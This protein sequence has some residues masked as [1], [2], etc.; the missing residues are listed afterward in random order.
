M[1]H[2]SHPNLFKVLK[3]LA[4]VII[5]SSSLQGCSKV[6]VYPWHDSTMGIASSNRSSFEKMRAIKLKGE[7]NRITG[8]RKDIGTYGVAT[9][10]EQ[11]NQQSLRYVL[12]APVSK[13]SVADIGSFDL[14]RAIQLPVADAIALKDILKRFLAKE[15]R[16]LSRQHGQFVNFSNTLEPDI[17]RTSKTS[18]KEKPQVKVSCSLLKAYKACRLVLSRGNWYRSYILQDHYQIELFTELLNAA[19]TID[20]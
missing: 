19:I 12:L 18:V 15:S 7:R 10:V 20:P 13:R 1:L 9:G 6:V 16:A 3:L 4:V 14:S 17:R 8:K 5:V 2:K 11:V